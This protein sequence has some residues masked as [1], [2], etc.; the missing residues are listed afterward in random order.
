MIVGV[1]KVKMGFSIPKEFP[2]V[3]KKK[4]KTGRVKTRD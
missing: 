4:K 3:S 2:T 1:A